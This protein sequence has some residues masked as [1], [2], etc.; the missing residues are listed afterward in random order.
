MK[1]VFLVCSGL[2]NVQRGYESFTQEC[3]EALQQETSLELFLFKGAG[4]SQIRVF[5]LPNMPRDSWLAEK[6]SKLFKQDNYFIEQF[7]FF[8]S[9]IPHI[10]QKRPDVIFFSDFNL[11][12]ILW[13]FRQLTGLS[14][15]LL[16]S[17]GAPNG[18]PFSRADHVQHLTPIHYQAALDS[19]EPESKHSLVPYGIKMGKDYNNLTQSE[20]E[21]LRSKLNLP[22]HRPLI[23]SVAAINKTHKRMD[24]LIQEVARLPEPRPYLMLLGQ[25]DQESPEIIQLGDR[26]LGSDNFQAKTVKY[27]EISNYYRSADLFVLA[28][29]N[30]GLPRVL[31]EAMGYGLPC[32]VH[33]YAVTRFV[34]KDWGYFANFA[35]CGS[36]NTL[37]KETLA[38][39]NDLKSQRHK[40]IYE[41]F[42]WNCLRSNYVDMI[43]LCAKGNPC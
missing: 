23:L 20:R 40:F 26:L 3:F 12:T 24:Y 27:N 43:H 1:K 35:T 10:Y 15:K 6:F 31:L 16:F 41:Y 32:L 17:N 4:K 8:L 7:T 9:L 13:H 22:T 28:S 2:G 14:Y 38:Q 25:I 5:T 42:S 18:P 37:I 19:G 29:L 36:L 33:D 21:A 34:L 30:E 11:G 39:N